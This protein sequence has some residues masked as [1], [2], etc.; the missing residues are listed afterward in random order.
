MFWQC[1]HLFDVL[2]SNVR[3]G[4]SLGWTLPFD[5]AILALGAYATYL[6]IDWLV[7]W[8]TSA[9]QPGFIKT[10]LGWVSGWIMVL[11]NA[12]LAL[13]YAWRGQPETVYAS[14][15]GDAHVSIPLCLGLYALFHTLNLPPF[16]HMSMFILLGATLV[17]LCSL[18]L[19]GQVPRFIGW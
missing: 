10:H 18:A 16:F 7:H 19:F 5:L 11:P 12:I 17:H 13:Y 8:V 14:Q 2:K 6:S 4:R 15:V 1:F 9:A 3:Q